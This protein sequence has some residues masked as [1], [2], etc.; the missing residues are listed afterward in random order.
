MTQCIRITPPLP[1]LRVHAGARQ[2]LTFAEEDV[3]L[4]IWEWFRAPVS[5]KARQAATSTGTM[6]DEAKYNKLTG[7]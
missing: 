2:P 6:R 4:R 7:T 3:A 5:R 1:P